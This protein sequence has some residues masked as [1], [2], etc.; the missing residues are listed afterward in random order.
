M[1]KRY[2]YKE[3]ILKINRFIIRNAT[4]VQKPLELILDSFEL[5][6]TLTI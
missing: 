5:R 2:L 1:R 3:N 4:Y 6:P